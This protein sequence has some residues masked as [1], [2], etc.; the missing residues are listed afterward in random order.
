MAHPGQTQRRGEG[1]NL[2][3]K[4]VRHKKHPGIKYIQVDTLHKAGM[5]K[6]KQKEELQRKLTC[7]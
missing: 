1:G 6:V 5:S 3:K 2:R 7:L 4:I